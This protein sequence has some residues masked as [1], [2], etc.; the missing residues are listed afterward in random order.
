MRAQ[1]PPLGPHDPKGPH[2]ITRRDVTSIQ[3]DAQNAA[4]AAH[5]LTDQDFIAAGTEARVYALDDTHV[6]KL[7]AGHDQLPALQTLRDFYDRLRPGAL[8]YT[9]PK[10]HDIQTHEGLVVVTERRIHGQPMEDHLTADDPD[11]ETLYLNTVA[12]LARVTLDRRLGRRQLLTEPGA[13][14]ASEPEDWN[15]FLTHLIRAKLPAVLPLLRQDI[16]HAD[17]RAE[18]LLHSLSAPYRGPEGV[19]HGD[20]FPGNILMADPHTVSGVIDFGTVTMIGDPLFDTAV[21]CGFYRMYESDH[22]ITRQRLLTRAA[23]CLRPQRRQALHVYLL[24][25]AL[26]TCDLYPHPD[27]PLRETGHYRW[28]LTVLDHS[29]YWQQLAADSAP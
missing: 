8:P 5:G 23:A 18:A 29:P 14:A 4:L 26:L 22:L 9:L 13:P 10:I 21:A 15:A 25:N 3:T 20:L 17:Q 24:A 19:I 11:L 1:P 7:Y 28:A 6:L 2:M 27:H 12:A 16:E